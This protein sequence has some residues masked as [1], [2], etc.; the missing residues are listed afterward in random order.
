VQG[1]APV[2]EV[3]A[4]LHAVAPAVGN[5]GFVHSL[6]TAADLF[7]YSVVER[8]D[9]PDGWLDGLTAWCADRGWLTS[10]Q[11]RKV[12]CVPGPLTKSAAVREVARRVGASRWIAVGDSL[13]D[14][15]MLAAADEAIRPA[16]GELEASAFALP[17]LTVTAA[18]GVLAGQEL[19]DWLLARS[20]CEAVITGG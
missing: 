3:H 11:G 14:G 13:L 20:S 9:V 7:V 19:T 16:H 18:R 6:R 10:M 5:G 4:H 15:E 2:E 17:N 8:A 1:C 12:Y